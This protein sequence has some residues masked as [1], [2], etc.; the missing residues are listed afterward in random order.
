MMILILHSA[1]APVLYEVNFNM[2]KTVFVG[3]HVNLTVQV[4]SRIPLI[5]MPLWSRLNAD[6]PKDS[7][8]VN[9]SQDKSNYTS[10]II[11]KAN[12]AND[13]GLYYLNTSNYCG[14]SGISVELNIDKGNY[15]RF[16]LVIAI[17]KD[18]CYRYSIEYHVVGYF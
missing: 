1:T 2:D 3:N 4:I 12:Y 8:V 15:M 11:R 10:L 5:S 17:I 7:D 9:Y 16:C 18:V 13:G 14:P 6:L